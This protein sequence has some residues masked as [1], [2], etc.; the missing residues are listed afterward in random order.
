MN[1]TRALIVFHALPGYLM[2][3]EC[4]VLGPQFPAETDCMGEKQSAPSNCILVPGVTQRKCSYF[5]IM[6]TTTT[7]IPPPPTPTPLQ[8]S[9]ID[10]RPNLV[11]NIVNKS[12]ESSCKKTGNSSSQWW[13]VGLFQ[14]F[15]WLQSVQRR[16]SSQPRVPPNHSEYSDV[17]LFG[18]PYVETRTS[19]LSNL[20]WVYSTVL[21]STV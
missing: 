11:E 20:T 15:N 5:N 10:C 17:F 1:A 4:Q 7:T 21:Y 6:N 12:S 2:I 18:R 3:M 8:P 13:L 19:V 14:Y 16:L 9:N